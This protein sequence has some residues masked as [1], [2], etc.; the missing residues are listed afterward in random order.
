MDEADPVQGGPGGVSNL[1]PRQLA[2]R[3]LYLKNIVEALGAGKLD[4]SAIASQAQAEAGADNTKWMT[5]L[6]VAQAIAA[7]ASI[8][9]A[10]DTS[11]GKVELATNAETIT[12]TDTTRAT[13]PAGVKAAIA[14]AVAAVVNSSP[15]TLDTLNELAAALGNDPNFAT[16]IATLIAGKQASD[17][18]LTALSGLT[19]A[20]NQM[21]YSTGADAFAMTSLTAFA[22]TLLDDADA[23]TARA[24]LGL[25][26]RPGHTYAANDWMPLGDGIILQWGTTASIASNA[27]SGTITFPIAFP[28]N[29]AY[30]NII[31]VGA[32]TAGSN[33]NLSLATK[34]AAN[35]SFINSYLSTEAF[36]WIAIGY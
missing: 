9:M 4:L 23:A 6:R 10:T 19:T 14:A 7:L 20:A 13:H 27:S 8:A 22:R 2:N 30:V 26:G 15:P 11:A 28:S 33:T 34:T 31:G 25:S 5:P 21:P 24:T 32:V 1:Q 35:F 3:T 12:G 29:A 16:S 17:A 18:T 36:N